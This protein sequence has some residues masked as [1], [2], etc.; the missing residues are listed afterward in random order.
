[1]FYRYSCM[2]YS[3]SSIVAKFDQQYSDKLP[4]S[5]KQHVS[6]LHGAGEDIATT[7]QPNTYDLVSISL[8][9]HELP[10][11][12]S[13]N[14]MQ[15]AYNVLKPGGVFAF[16]DMDP[17][18]PAFQRVLKNPFAFAAFKSTEPWLQEYVRLDLLQALKETGFSRIFVLANSPR[19]RTIVAYK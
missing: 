11:L 5:A 3:M 18:S 2:V 15:Q 6:F 19:H 8:V 17:G 1:M 14:I 7:L 9:S 4:A 13:A 16:M 12:T 10:E